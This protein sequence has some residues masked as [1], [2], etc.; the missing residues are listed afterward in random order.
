MSVLLTTLDQD[1][2]ALP[3]EEGSIE[4]NQTVAQRQDIVARADLEKST[5]SLL[6]STAQAQS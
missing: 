6:Q 2:Q 1:V 4:N 5:D 3:H